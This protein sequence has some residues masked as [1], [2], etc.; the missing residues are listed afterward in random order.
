M[1]KHLV[2]VES[3]A[4]AKTINKFLG[5]N[6]L[7]KASMGHVR[8]LPKS[9]LGVDV[10]DHFK[11][12]YITIRSRSKILKEL[13]RMANTAQHIYLA[14][15]PD[16]EGEAISWHLSKELQTAKNQV[17]RVMFNEITKKTVLEAI[18][19]PLEINQNMVNAQQARRILDRL[20]GYSIS[21][22]LWKKVRKGLSAGRVQS[23]TVRLVVNRERE[24]EAF[25]PKEYWKIDVLLET[26]DKASLLSHVTHVGEQKIDIDNGTDAQAVV[27]TLNT[28][29]YRVSH[30]EK[31]EQRRKP[32]APFITSKL[33]QEA[34]SK[35]HFTAKKTMMV[36][37]QLYEG[38]EIGQDGPVGLITYMRTDSMRVNEEAQT[39]ARAYISE[40]YGADFVPE[41]PPVYK[42]KKQIQDAHEAIRPSTPSADYT[43][44]SLKQYLSH[45]QYRL[46]KLIWQRFLASQMTPAVFDATTVDIEAGHVRLRTTG[47]ILKFKGFTTVYMETAAEGQ[48]EAQDNQDSHLPD[49]QQGQALFL[50]EI[51]PEQKFTQPP[52]RYNDASLVKALEENNIGRPSTYAPIISTILDRDYVE[53]REGRFFP[54]ELGMIINDLL[55][56]HFP[57]ILDVE[58][59]AAMENNLDSIE[60]G[61]AQW[62]QVLAQ[63]YQSFKLELDKAQEEMK[64][65]KSKVEVELEQRCEKCGSPLTVKWG[66]HGKFIACTNYPACKN[67]KPMAVDDQGKIVVKEEETVEET[68]EKCGS[69]LVAKYGRFGR[70]LACSRYPECKFT[71]AI[72]QE[73]G[74]AC[75]KPDCG[76]QIIERRSKKGRLFYGCSHY[77]KCDFVS[78]DRPVP[79]AC[80]VCG[81]AYVVE[82]Y[83]KKTG[84]TIQCPAEGCDYKVALNPETPS[85]GQST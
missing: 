24:I 37:Q 54:T 44:D 12:H 62:D 55:V 46:Y 63:F 32:P 77:P 79:Q 31:K 53:R 42:S 66:R 48:E 20:V 26:E 17:H 61:Q 27:E 72:N 59:T 6:Y 52:P 23:V 38:L 19:K 33:Q 78:W 14:A 7:V 73:I 1:A 84:K 47:S 30:I 70:F 68:C 56:E 85:Q 69:P 10:E 36:A 9:K 29:A 5:K 35:L 18:Q 82:K 45:D 28:A 4:K 21:P 71:K 67:T 83:S 22:L 25:L 15:D 58:F 41:K 76:G 50:L 74:V 3:P 16:R 60:E 57:D 75:P 11:P 81:Q 39:Q 80:P 13:K 8:D 51:K 64:N 34:A 43:P 65:I 2:I 40:H 49:L